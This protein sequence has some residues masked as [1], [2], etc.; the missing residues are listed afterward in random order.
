M[1]EGW[2]KSDE[3][4]HK[5]KKFIE[6]STLVA[7]N[8]KFDIGFLKYEFNRLGFNLN[9]SYI[10]TLQLSRMH[11]P[12]LSNHRLETVYHYV[13]GKLHECSPRTWG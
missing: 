5:L 9:N 10:C 1:L 2:P 6:K 12:R 11:F 7:H 3:V 4:F 13:T 8:A